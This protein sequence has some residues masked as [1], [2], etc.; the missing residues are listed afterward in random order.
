[1]ELPGFMLVELA[2]SDIFLVGL[3]HA[4][5]KRLLVAARLLDPLEHVPGRLLRSIQ[6][7][8][9]L[10]RGDA[11]ARHA[12]LVHHEEP[13]PNRYSRRFH[14]GAHLAGELLEA[15]LAVV[16]ALAGLVPIRVHTPAFGQNRPFGQR[17]DSKNRTALSSLPIQL[18]NSSSPI[19]VLFVT[20]SHPRRIHVCFR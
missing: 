18:R 2:A 17:R 7:L 15:V 5:E 13:L 3:H 10:Q 6:L 20:A 12:D 19:V 4:G 9:K 14:D 8:G 11:L 1:M 16:V